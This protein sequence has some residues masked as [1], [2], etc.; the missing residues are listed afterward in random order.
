MSLTPTLRVAECNDEETSA[1]SADMVD[2]LKG[3]QEVPIKLE[4]ML[5]AL[6]TLKATHEQAGKRIEDRLEDLCERIDQQHSALNLHV[7]E[8]ETRL[9]A[10]EVENLGKNYAL[11]GIGDELNRLAKAIDDGDHDLRQDVVQLRL[12][13]KALA[14][15]AGPKKKQHMALQWGPLVAALTALIGMITQWVSAHLPSGT[16]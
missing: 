8:D 3:L 7:K 10:L 5:G 12:D 6:E 1:E 9:K 11:K 13:V 2:E 16:P 14:E 15:S 4:R